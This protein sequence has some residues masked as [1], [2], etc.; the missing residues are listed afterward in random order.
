MIRVCTAL[1][2]PFFLLLAACDQQE[3]RLSRAEALAGAVQDQILET[4]AGETAPTAPFPEA[5]KDD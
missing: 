1:V 5:A 2:M 4:V 3:E